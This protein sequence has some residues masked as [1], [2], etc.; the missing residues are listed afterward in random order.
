VRLVHEENEV[1]QLGQ[2]L[3][4][5]LADVLLQTL[6]ARFRTAAHL[7]VD[8]ADVEDVDVDWSIWVFEPRD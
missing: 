3:E 5:T 8:L 2:V 4:V 7:R 6:D 1:V